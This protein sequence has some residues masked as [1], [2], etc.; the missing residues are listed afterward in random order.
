MPNN[1]KAWLG[2]KAD[3]YT[4]QLDNGQTVQ[5]ALLRHRKERLPWANDMDKLLVTITYDTHEWAIYRRDT[6]PT[7]PLRY[8]AAM[9]RMTDIHLTKLQEFFNWPVAQAI[10]DAY[11]LCPV[12]AGIPTYMLAD[13]VMKEWRK[14]PIA[15]WWPCHRGDYGISFLRNTSD[16]R[17]CIEVRPTKVHVY[18][19]AIEE[20]EALLDKRIIKTW[21][22]EEL[23]LA[24]M[25]QLLPKPDCIETRLLCRTLMFLFYNIALKL[26]LPF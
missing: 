3:W 9:Y 26:D 8:S 15:G 4:I 24:K 17:N 6:L 16:G 23:D 20:N 7:D 21:Q 22:I 10:L 11:T 1:R 25:T 19:G 2:I 14:K 18:S 5:A 12:S 13:E